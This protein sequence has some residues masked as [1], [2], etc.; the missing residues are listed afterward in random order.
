MTHSGLRKT[1]FRVAAIVGLIL[2]I[3]VFGNL[4]LTGWNWGPGDFALAFAALFATGLAIDLAAHRIASPAP[5]LAVIGAAVL[6]LMALWAEAV[7]GLM[8]K[9]VAA[10][11][12]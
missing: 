6:A 2:L 11:L 12:G 10:L 4:F 5:R 3:P 9:T 1:F 7:G 8:S